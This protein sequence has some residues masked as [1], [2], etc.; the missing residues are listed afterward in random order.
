VLFAGVFHRRFSAILH[1]PGRARPPRLPCP[2]PPPARHTLL[3]ISGGRRLTRGTREKGE[4]ASGLR[5]AARCYTIILPRRTPQLLAPPNETVFEARVGCS[6]A[7]AIA[8]EDR[9]S[10]GL[11][12]SAA[13]AAGFGPVVVALHVL[14]SSAYRA[15][16]SAELPRGA[17]L[18]APAAVQNPAT[19]TLRWRPSKGQEGFLYRFCFTTSVADNDTPPLCLRVRLLRCQFCAR[20]ADSLQA[21]AKLWHTTWAE[22][23]PPYPTRAPR[24]PRRFDAP[25]AVYCA[26][27][28][29]PGHPWARRRYGPATTCCRTR[30][31]FAPT[32]R[33]PKPFPTRPPTTSATV[34]TTEGN[35]P[36]HE[37][38]HEAALAP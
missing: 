13:A 16:L 29:R 11:A 6:L 12:P 15:S 14:T 9:T 23:T 7:I 1:A 32:R 30:T 19:A 18:D 22:V 10:A 36:T 28:D 8:A 21:M 5:T 35:P 31:S 3:P 34:A 25:R 37:A 4:D 27:L 26:Q 33:A 20:P 17:A 38:A 2:R 24:R